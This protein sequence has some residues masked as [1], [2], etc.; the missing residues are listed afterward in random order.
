MSLMAPL[1]FLMGMGA[2]IV[3]LLLD[4]GTV[5]SLIN[6][7]AMVLVLVG[8]VGA[9]VIGVTSTDLKKIPGLLMSI[10]RPKKIDIEGNVQKI[11]ELAEVARREGLLR[12]EDELDKGGLDPFLARGLGLVVDGSDEE[13]IR[14]IMGEDLGVFEED[15]AAG[16]AIFETAGGYAPTLGII[17]TVMGLVSVLG[18]LSDVAKLAP[19][20]ATAFTATL[21]GVST[22]N[23]FWLP[24]SNNLKSQ[25]RRMVRE[26]TMMIE[27]CVAI[28]RGQNPRVIQ[29]ALSVYLE[30]PPKPKPK[31]DTG[32]EA[33]QAEAD[34][35]AS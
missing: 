18:S 2:L 32:P 9:T 11:A 26:R 21:W 23:L 10:V 35:A 33:A 6:P 19:S 25:T 22:A 14:Q 27:G 17:G 3:S 28:S 12:L 7:S 31:D 1:G 15:Q 34:R 8:T 5:R 16:A 30:F 29:D 20:I 13:R 24:L 4:G